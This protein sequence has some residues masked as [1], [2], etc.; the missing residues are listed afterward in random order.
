MWHG[1]RIWK[2]KLLV[3]NTSSSQLQ[4]LFKTILNEG[5]QSLLVAYQ[6]NAG[7]TETFTESELQQLWQQGLKT[8]MPAYTYQRK[9]VEESST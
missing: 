6:N 9:E 1:T 8:R 4:K 7:K 5:K 3:S 2:G